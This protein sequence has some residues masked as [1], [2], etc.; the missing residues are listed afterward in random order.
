VIDKL[1]SLGIYDNT[2]IV[3]TSDNGGERFSYNWP[4]LGKKGELLEGGIR[5]P[6]IVH[7]PKKI[8]P[9]Q[10]NYQVAMTMDWMPTLLEAIDADE[11]LYKNLDGISL[12]DSLFTESPSEDRDV[13]WRF[14][15]N[16]QAA[17]RSGKWK[18]LKIKDNEFLFDLS[19]DEREQANLKDKHPDIVEKL[20]EKYRIW[21]EQ[22]LPYPDE[23]YS[24]DLSDT[25]TDR[26]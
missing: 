25:Y 14:K 10:S 4:F 26:Y 12:I 15:N 5:V 21:N 8:A 19:I 23:S 2:I 6:S 17:V 11:N 16:S 7:W 1:K 18:Y 22:M 13:F 3:F 9:N 24:H 20:K